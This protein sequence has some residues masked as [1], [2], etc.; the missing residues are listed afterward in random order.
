MGC[1]S[2]YGLLVQ[3]RA[4]RES[5]ACSSHSL[6]QPPPPPSNSLR[7]V[8]EKLSLI[9]T[10][11]AGT[12]RCEEVF[13]KQSHCLSLKTNFQTRLFVPNKVLT[14]HLTLNYTECLNKDRMC[15]TSATE[16]MFSSLFVCL[17]AGLSKKLLD[18]LLGHFVE[19]WG[20]RL[21]LGADPDQGADPGYSLIF[22]TFFNNAS[23]LQPF[24][25][26]F[27]R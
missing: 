23:V 26:W 2:N 4:T 8:K 6:E 25:R 17:L 1:E 21:N 18:W 16:V 22:F 13:L 14:S 27:L 20:N 11:A 24:F 15:I 12:V 7:P 19:G 9:I 3:P 5:C 10:A